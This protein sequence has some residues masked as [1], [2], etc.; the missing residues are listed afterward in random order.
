MANSNDFF[1]KAKSA[2]ENCEKK[3]ETK[4]EIEF[5]HVL[6]NYFQWLGFPDIEGQYEQKAGNILI[7][8]KKRQDATYGK[9]IIEYE[10][11]GRLLTHAGKSH[12]LSQI[13][14]DYL[15]IYPPAQREELVGIVFDGKLVIFVRWVEN[16]WD[17]DER[18]FGSQ[19]F[20]MMVNFLVGLYKISFSELPAQF[21]FN[22]A[23]TR[24]A[25][26]VLYSKSFC[27]NERA[28]MLFDE[29]NL[30]FSSI[31][32]NSFSKKKIK[33]HFKEFAKEV[34]IEEAEEGRLIFAIHTYYAFIVKIVAS[35]VAKNLFSYARAQ[36]HMRTLL[37]SEKL[38]KELIDIEDGKFFRDIGIENFIE[39]TFLSW[40][41]DVWDNDI[42][43]IVK[44]I[45]TRLDWF[46]FAEFITKPEHVVDY[47]KNF[48]QEVFSQDLRHDL[49]E[50]YT[51]DWLAKYVVNLAGFDGDINKR[52]LDPACGSGTFLIAI[53]N[54][55]FEKYKKEQKKE[56]L[57]ADISKNV[58]GFDINP[59]AV[60]TARTNYLIALS[61]FNLE[62]TQVT[63]PIYLTDSIVLP[64]L[65]KQKKL[66]DKVDLYNIKTTK[67]IFR[68]PAEVKTRISEV[69]HLLK[70]D[71][72]KQIDREDAEEQLKKRF[73][74]S[75]KVTY[76]LLELYDRLL[77]LSSQN[78]NRIWC[79][80]VINQ[81]STLFQE[82]FDF[83]IGNPPWVNWE[84]LNDEY[85][86]HLMAINDEYGMY[87]T[88]GLESRL[89]KVKRDISAI[90][91]YVSSDIYLKNHGSIAFLIKPMYQ[92]P[93]G[94]GFRNF[95]RLPKDVEIRKLKNPLKVVTVEDVSKENPFEIGNA[96]SLIVAKK[97]E[98]TEYPIKYRKWAG[99]RT[100]ELEDYK[101]EPADDTD[102]LSNWAI[103]KGKKKLN[104]TGEFDY[105]IRTGVYHGLKEPFFGLELLTDK[106]TL[107]QIRNCEG[108]VKDLEK[109][110]IYPL[111]MSR[112]VNRWKLGDARGV[113]YTYCILPQS[114]LGENNENEMKLD[115]PNTY[116]W[117]SDFKEKLL[118]RKI[119]KTMF[120][121][122][123]NPFYSI[124]DLNDWDSK[125]KV[126]WKNMGFY[127]DFLVISSVD[128]E[129]LG[130]KL[131][132]P[133]HVISY[134][135]LAS[136]KEAH[137]VCAILNSSVARASLETLSGGGKSGLSGSIIGN[138]RLD[139][140][141]PK[142]PL[143]NVLSALSISAHSLAEKNDNEK[144]QKLEERIS[145]KVEAL[146]KKPK[147]ETTL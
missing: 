54:K 135:P 89:G 5:E 126:V 76:H 81:F 21:G 147:Q 111:I 118:D 39:G 56:K 51:P 120:H 17:Y 59:I 110:R 112:H 86:K 71:V 124:Y 25:L 143:H 32:G 63:I 46:D 97:G 22:K 47:L 23:K 62:K 6:K 99:K 69:M 117:L 100:H 18:E 11:V 121:A 113:K 27:K 145:D 50:F 138:M 40:Y 134:I 68:I 3:P 24:E 146:Y 72:D 34:G 2:I 95:N 133:E 16:N 73:G 78:Q 28:K 41:L 114:R 93:S 13:T 84:F 38:E 83:V 115:T 96:V 101:A 4:L 127:P 80:I 37:E 42:E 20:E 67:G 33:K 26:K 44:D 57:V 106:G 103:F 77:E 53:L 8:S 131:I 79:D 102:L 98:K 142:N 36:S 136:E 94:R 74:Y 88:K 85:Q 66:T 49:G 137:Y 91:F 87:F 45:I 65:S 139:K 129:K 58:V 55:I 29:W 10:S 70:S 7:V 122:G 128:D 108:R 119:F 30:R 90:F 92:I 52:V 9:V 104:A 130:T 35:E 19:S 43:E 64:E 61:R 82:R 125:Y 141:N 60:L 48:Y 109:D 116:E 132:L 75:D 15:G 12:A 31:Y 1:E 105:K 107:V 123:K 14:D 144:L 140:F